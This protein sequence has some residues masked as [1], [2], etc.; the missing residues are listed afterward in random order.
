MPTRKRARKREGPTVIFIEYAYYLHIQD[1]ATPGM[2]DISR[3]RTLGLYTH[4]MSSPL[5]CIHDDAR[6]GARCALCT[7]C[8]HDGVYEF[9]QDIV[10]KFGCHAS[11]RSC[12]CV[13]FID[14]GCIQCNCE[15]RQ[16]NIF[17]VNP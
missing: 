9:R 15:Q 5:V 2:V 12:A 14:I 8:L 13:C 7:G 16:N 17:Y 6:F 11:R 4:T 3:W 10:R 1:F